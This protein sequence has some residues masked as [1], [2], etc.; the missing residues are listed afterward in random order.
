MAWEPGTHAGRYEILDL[1]GE[2]AMAK[3]FRA[4]DTT[5]RR[6]VALKVLPEIFS[7][8]QEYMQRFQGEARA[9]GMLNHLNI[10]AVCHNGKRQ[11][12]PYIVT[13]L[14][15]GE[16]LRGRINKG[17]LSQGE[18]VGFARQIAA[19]LAA[20]HDKGI[21]HRDLKPENIFITRDGVAKILDFGLFKVVT[22][23][24][25]MM[26]MLSPATQSGMVVGAV[27]Y[28]SPEQAHA[29]P[30]DQ[31]SDTFSF[32]SILYEM[33]SGRLLVGQEQI[34]HLLYASSGSKGEQVLRWDNSGKFLF[35]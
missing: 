20:A 23:G 6:E 22:E 24:Q 16:T 28:M 8:D 2:G 32:G 19:G 25:D 10:V 14:L 7:D 4:R 5:L 34:R 3:V 30:I 33:L 15:D 18:S 29:K 12:L 11:G 31:R 9:V 21:T 13:E 35:V 1:L 26:S 17:P 27:P